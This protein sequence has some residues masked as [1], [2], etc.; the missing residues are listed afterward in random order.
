MAGFADSGSL[1]QRLRQHQ[2]WIGGIERGKRS[3]FFARLKRSQ[4]R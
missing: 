4:E 2:T 3:S 1:G